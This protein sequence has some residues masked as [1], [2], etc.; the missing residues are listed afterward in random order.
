MPSLN[1]PAFQFKYALRNGKKMIF[2][3]FRK[4]FVTLTPEE[5]VRQHF[6]AW[7]HYCKGY[8]RGLIS[9]EAPLRY[10][11]MQKRADAIV[12]A[13]TGHP[14]MIIECKAPEVVITQDVFDQIARYNFS[15][16]VSFLAVTNGMD[17]YCCTKPDNDDKWVF[18]EGVPD[19]GALLQ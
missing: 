6:L 14:I 2:D 18:L 7:L 11:N 1:L 13:N 9:V 8:P 16:G 4:K 17:H 12:Y 10:N 19:Y 5:W 3:P 15:F